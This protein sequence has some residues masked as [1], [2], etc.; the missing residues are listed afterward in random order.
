MQARWEQRTTQQCIV[1]LGAIGAGTHILTIEVDR[2][3]DRP[4]DRPMDRPASKGD[5][6]TGVKIFGIY[7]Q[8]LL[9][10]L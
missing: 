7:V 5:G 3:K 1:P 8:N 4:K 9:A 10:G 6:G 2:P